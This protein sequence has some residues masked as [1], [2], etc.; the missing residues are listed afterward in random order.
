MQIALASGAEPQT[1]MGG[2]GG[3]PALPHTPWMGGRGAP[4]PHLPRGGRGTTVI[5]RCTLHS[6]PMPLGKVWWGCWG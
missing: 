1:P 4:L 3:L 2:G 5:G 6:L